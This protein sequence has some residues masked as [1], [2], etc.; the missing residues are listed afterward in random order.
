MRRYFSIPCALVVL[1][2]A[3]G[4][5]FVLPED[6]GYQFTS[7]DL[8]Q[9]NYGWWR[10]DEAPDAVADGEG[11][12]GGD[13]SRE[14]TEPDVFRRDANILYVLNQYRGLTL[15]DLDTEEVLAQLPTYG[16]PR[17]LYVRDGRAYVLVGQATN[18]ETDGN[19]INYT[20]QGRLF[21]ADVSAPASAKLLSSIALEGDFVDSRLVGDVLYAVCA[22]FDWYWDGVVAVKDQ[23]SASWVTS[24]N[25]ADADNI[26]Q[27]DQVSFGGTG[28]VIQ[29]TPTAIF[30][31][32]SAQWTSEP[33]TITYVDISD[34]EGTME[35]RGSVDVRGYVADRYKLD[36]WEG[37]LRVVTG[38]W[39]DQRRVFLTTINLA[40]PDNLTV[41]A[42][43][44][45]ERASG[46][47]VFATRFDGPKAYIVTFLVK[48][49][50]FVV[51]LSDPAAPTLVGEL[52]V[53]GWST[54]IEPRGDRLIALGVDDTE[55]QRVCVS[56]FD[57]ADP[58][59]PALIDRVSFGEAW[60]WSSAY[61][62]VKA[63]SVF[64][65]LLIVPFSGWNDSGGYER[66]QFV[67][68]S[69]E[70]LSVRGHVDLTG[71]AVRS[72]DYEG[73]YYGITMEQLVTIDGS[74]LDAP[75]VT[76]RLVLAE[77]VAD[78]LEVTP[79]VGAE[80]IAHYDTGKTVVRPTE[81]TKA[82]GAEVEVEIGELVD[83]VVYGNSVVLV[84]AS[85]VESPH[86]TVAIVDCSNP[87]QPL[88]LDTLQVP[89]QPLY[90]WY[91]PVYPYGP[92]PE[93]DRDASTADAIIGRPFYP[94]YH[95]DAVF[96]LGDRL[97]LRCRADSYD[98]VLGPDTADQGLAMVDL[99]DRVFAGTAG[100]AFDNIVSLNAAGAKM[101]LTTCE[102][103]EVEPVKEP[104]NPQCAYFVTSIDLAGTPS[105]GPSA[106]V[107]GI[108]VQYEPGNGVLALSDDQ[109]LEGG[110]FQSYLRTV[111][112]DGAEEVE[113]LDEIQLSEGTSQML[114]RGSKVYLETYAEGLKL[115]AVSVSP[116]GALALGNPVLVTK[117][118]GSLL[119][120]WGSSAYVVL[121]GNAIALYDFSSGEGLLEEIVPVMS[122][123]SKL[124]FGTSAAYAST[125]YSGVVKLPL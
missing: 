85:W 39:E 10:W 75:S 55:G 87:A 90:W 1:A 94:S 122:T 25:V 18:Y 120:A 104:D 24:V 61:S 89:V 114:G 47:S 8:R 86:Y 98:T 101:Y 3:V 36:A 102:P 121:G 79:E 49:P 100:L 91:W 124:R 82:S 19:T 54:H 69:P 6:T 20:V 40:D 53:P 73:N 99:A 108:F 4:C 119:D 83:T 46:E 105:A 97:V 106:N 118:W 125:G 13:V 50:L 15:V 52:E 64:D 33:T 109:W 48:D 67:S 107:P 77:Y 41:L 81:L 58:G 96:L 117:D 14:V 5:P 112:W 27:A 115:Y 38:A 12:E 68:W 42:E 59:G 92:V 31:A 110:E 65:D 72:F 17:D 22:E 74:N 34:P 2:V 16:Y 93:V 76:N 26:Y 51:D 11:Q 37:T 80:V 32:S 21:I 84:G 70:D 71:A 35:V 103:V 30:V 63:F 9:S 56:L 44:E 113:S 45:L 43:L 7:A 29:A 66:L 111:H 28:N 78:F 57:V 116:D 88:V 95:S 23:S 62:D 123:P 60:S